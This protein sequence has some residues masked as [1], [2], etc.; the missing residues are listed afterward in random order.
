M[1]LENQ[2][3]IILQILNSFKVGVESISAKEGPTATMFE[4]RPK[5]GVRISR[6]KNLTEEIA[7]GL[8]SDKV[9][10][11]GAIPGHGTVGIEVPNA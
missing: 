11:T 5:I 1:D 7:V 4:I 8:C 6:I 3:Q 10:F 2:K 9:R